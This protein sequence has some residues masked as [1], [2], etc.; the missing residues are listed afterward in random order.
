MRGDFTR[1]SHRPGRHYA[2][3]LMQ[4]GRVQLDADWNE[5]R[6][7]DGQRWR[8]QTI[9][10]I[11]ASG[12]PAAAPGFKIAPPDGA[13]LKFLSGRIYV[14]GLFYEL[15][16]DLYYSRQPD[17]PSPE[18]LRPRNGETDLFYLDVWSR[19]VTAVEDPKLREIALGGPDTATRVQT[20][21]QVKFIEDV[22]D[23]RCDDPQQ[24]FDALVRGKLSQGEMSARARP[25]IQR[26]PD[27]PCEV[28]PGT[29]FRGVENRLYRVEIHDGGGFG[30][31]PATFVW[32][33]DNGSVLASVTRFKGG[34]DN[35]IE[36]SSLGRDKTLRFSIGDWVEVLSDR[37]ELD[38]KPGTIARITDVDE[39]SRTLSLSVPV[40]AHD[41][42]YYPRVR[43]WDQKSPPIEVTKATNN[44]FELEDG[45]EIKFTKPGFRT[46]DFWVIPTR[47]A[48]GTVE[49]FTEARPRGIEHHYSRLALV[50]WTS[51]SKEKLAYTVE[52]CVASFPPLTERQGAGCCTVT[53]GDGTTSRGDF[54][55]LQE[56]VDSLTGPGRVCVLP[57][58]YRPTDTVTIDRTGVVVSGCGGEA[59][60][61]A[62][63]G[64]PALRVS[65]AGNVRLEE[66][67]VEANAT[68]AVE[69]TG[70]TGLQVRGCRLTSTGGEA[71][72]ISDSEDVEVLACRLDG[73]QALSVQARRV[74]LAGNRC[75]AGGIWL[76]DGSA[77]A[78][79]EDNDITDGQGAGVALG[80]LAPEQPPSATGAGVARVAVVG[81]RIRGMEASGVATVAPTGDATLADVRDLTVAGNQIRRCARQPAQASYDPEAVGGITLRDVSMV[82]IHDNVIV[83]NGDGQVPACGIFVHTCQGLRV[84]GNTVTGNGGP[85]DGD[86]PKVYQAGIVA[87][88]AV[89]GQPP[90]R[91][92]AP[93]AAR[94]DT[95]WP[96]AAVHDN[97][98]ASPNG[99]ALI[100][101]AIGPVSVAGNT[102]TV[103]E[104]ALQPLQASRR[105]SAVFLVNLGRTPVLSDAAT[106]FG[107]AV[108][109]SLVQCRLD[110][111]VLTSPL[112]EASRPVPAGPVL[113]HGNQVSLRL[114]QAVVNPP[115]A[116]VTII[117][118][119]D[120]ALLD[121]QLLTRIDDGMVWAGAQAFAPT[122]RASGNR[123]TETPCRAVFSYHSVGLANV[124]TGNQAN[125]CIGVLGSQTVD[126]DNQI[127]LGGD[128]QR[129]TD[130]ITPGRQ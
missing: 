21:A 5:Q 79:I 56:A 72:V 54:D 16:A 130:A 117:S 52:E 95:A 46:G 55:D 4:Q 81:N 59:R 14:D 110:E 32:S 107:K 90:G 20:V 116:A 120:A 35:Q 78:Q 69:A 33:R 36:V 87:M 108:G 122:L 48:P 60:I 28:V 57:G 128:C 68:P 11:G 42:K 53:V 109:T 58:H 23:L 50:T 101:T 49:G 119:D 40:Q 64:K 30:P 15:A 63:T 34:P 45:V 76:R 39:A 24:D 84:W 65:Q 103:L 100:V 18:P 44:W 67:R 38:G 88:L 25:G 92:A 26:A 125:H 115:S 3:V 94:V 99:H 121:N 47:V 83:D 37:T 19:H 112:P 51:S 106:G 66:L 77:D 8:G 93:E 10:T 123:F 86:D 62:P 70:C 129:I 73:R 80:G 9:D 27:D 74:R 1:F 114:A 85:Q 6:D 98:V 124:A 111:D 2:D 41:P 104:P 75:A 82:R 118:T 13:D 96:A 126:E 43:R 61:T 71:L 31:N 22:G 102:L 7:I 29:G 17:L 113:F 12:R 91:A 127:L 97:T 105:G 89:G